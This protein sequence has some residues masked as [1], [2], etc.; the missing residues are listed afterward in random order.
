MPCYTKW[1]LGAV[2][3]VP[4]GQVFRQI[5]LIVALPLLLGQ[6]T[7]SVLIALA[8]ARFSDRLF[9]PALAVKPP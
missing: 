2:V 3:D 5:I 9:G 1:L 7:R 4:L 8:L 6:I